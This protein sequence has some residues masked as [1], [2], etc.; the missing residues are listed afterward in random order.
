[1]KALK[2]LKNS[3]V[4]LIS[5]IALIA[6]VCGV[7]FG[8]GNSVSASALSAEASSADNNYKFA[9]VDVNVDVNEDKTM[10]ITENLYTTFRNS[11]TNTGFI[12]DIQRITRIKRKVHDKDVFG[13]DI[14]APLTDIQF[15]MFNY[16]GINDYEAAIEEGFV[17][18]KSDIFR[19]QEM[20]S[21][22]TYSLYDN[23]QFHS[24]KMQQQLEYKL[25]AGT[26]LFQ[27]SYTYDL[28]EDKAGGF[29]DLT[30]DVLG[31]DMNYA[32]AVHG[33]VNFPKSID[34]SN[35]GVYLNNSSAFEG[36][37]LWQP[38]ASEGDR[39]NVKDT[40]V[41]FYTCLNTEA[42]RSFTVQVILP[43]GYFKGLGLT[44]FWYY[45]PF[46]VIAAAAVVALVI[47]A[48]KMIDKKPLETVEFYPP[49]GM[50]V[51]RF[52]SIWHR[53]VRDKDTA[54]L[55]LKWAGLGLI[56]IQQDGY[57]DVILRPT[58]KLPTRRGTR[59]RRKAPAA[60]VFDE[61]PDRV[62][63]EPSTG[64]VESSDP[65]GFGEPD[66][67]N[68]ISSAEMKKYFANAAERNYY[69]ALFG[70]IGGT[71]M[72]SSRVFSTQPYS[73]Q[74]R[75]YEVTEALKRS[76]ETPPALDGRL[77]K[78]AK[79]LFP[80]ISLIPMV[81]A[82]AYQCILNQTFVP[83]FFLIFMA[84]GSF[85]LPSMGGPRKA[86]FIAYIFPIAFF[87]MPYFAFIMMGT[88]PAYDY[89]RLMY[90][91]PFIW[92]IGNFALPL[93]KGRRTEEAHKYYGQML[94][95]KNFLLKAELPRIQKLFDENPE[96]FAD[97]LPW[98]FIMGIS[99]KVE[100]RFKSL[101]IKIN[102]PQY[103]T[104]RVNVYVLA[105]CMRRAYYS[106]AP[107]SSGGGHGGFGGGG[108]GGHGGSSGGG[109]GGGGS[110]G[111]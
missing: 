78:K 77:S 44:F 86:I 19:L 30:L 41:E 106:G 49:E 24:I 9:L 53:G 93:L 54:A 76:G 95:F 92:A 81:C 37:A 70:G 33:K 107:R 68:Q 71:N 50:S 21:K 110:R 25:D 32:A 12:R 101:E 47:L 90:I 66:G 1:M 23:G 11:N 46:V 69:D 34:R 83:L 40:S 36:R 108:G 111:C 13:S 43:D 72:F 10:R 45:I 91:A 52:S 63:A 85:V 99:D 79:Y 62:S 105:G 60:N 64:G 84:A 48:L 56:T 6:A 42:K 20:P 65:F 61:F 8:R 102:M 51:M 94:G 39:L 15:K 97:I 7:V 26:Y 2:S 3:F 55:I 18:D 17:P 59:K 28:S 35:A 98:C 89:I 75:L 74:R 96:Y 73:A 67:E 58:G 104:D 31:Y 5:V 29:D 22:Y 16:N 14:F 100:K 103:V 82:I 27:L 87:A 88:M 80:Y 4:I 109:G 57:S 38:D